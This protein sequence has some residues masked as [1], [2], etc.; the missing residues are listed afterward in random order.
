MAERCRKDAASTHHK[1]GHDHAQ[2]HR[3]SSA[4]SPMLR[5]DQTEDQ[6]HFPVQ[7]MHSIQMDCFCCL[8]AP[9]PTATRRTTA[10]GSFDEDP[11]GQ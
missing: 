10:P 11:R 5:P 1:H 7:A 6:I 8:A 4:P 9:K 2:H 3:P